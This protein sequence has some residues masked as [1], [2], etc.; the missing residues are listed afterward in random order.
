LNFTP[1]GIVSGF[2]WVP[3]G[4]AHVC[5]VRTAGLAIAQATLSIMI[6]LVSFVWGIFIFHESIHSL[7]SACFSIFLIIFGICGMSHYSSPS[8]TKAISSVEMTKVE[9]LSILSGES[10]S[11]C[12]LD[13][14]I[15][16]L[17]KIV[18]TNDDNDDNPKIINLNMRFAKFADSLNR[19]YKWNLNARH[20]GISCST[21]GGIWAGSIMVPLQFSN[22]ETKG[23]GFVFSFAIGAT[24]VTISLWILRFFY[25]YFFLVSPLSEKRY[26]QAYHTLPSF[27]VKVMLLPGSTAGLLWSIGNIGSILSV[28]YLGEG[29]GYSVTQ[30]AML[31]SGL[32][33]IFWFR[34]ITN[35]HDIHMWIISAIVTIIGILLLSSNHI[36]HS[37]G[38]V[39][40]IHI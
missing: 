5:G 32:W 23:L 28:T 14:Y 7:P 2:F 36:S 11:S 35:S 39:S 25:Y 13:E 37:E 24:L 38:S 3:A 18:G 30:S 4:V 29:I 21:F 1:W 16:P 12:S 22:S 10:R 33:G 31:I 20:I 9:S 17:T 6:V 34:E 8:P 26:L 15:K 27:H 40:T 19:K